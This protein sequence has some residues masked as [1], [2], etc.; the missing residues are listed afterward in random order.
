MTITKEDYVEL[1]AR[2]RAAAL[3]FVRMLNDKDLLL[4]Q[5]TE[6][7]QYGKV[8]IA[9]LYYKMTLMQ[10]WDQ[11]TPLASLDVDSEISEAADERLVQILPPGS[12]PLPPVED[13]PKV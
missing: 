1:L 9:A 5:G 12:W 3:I 13:W 8:S 11:L 4:D 6:T 2:Y 10:G 7:T